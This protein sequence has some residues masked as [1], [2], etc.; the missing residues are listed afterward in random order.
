MRITQN[1][2]ATQVLGNITGSLGRLAKAQEQLASTKR[3]NRASD[4]PLG[5][6][7]VMRFQATK[8]GL[9][10]FQR[11]TDAAQEALRGTATPLERVTEILQ[12][13]REV[14]V[15]GSSDTMSGSRGPLAEEVNQLLE[16]LLSQANSRFRDRYIFGGTQTGTTPYSASRNAT[17][18]ITAVTAN[19]LG[20]D[21]TVNAEVASGFSVQS[22]LPGSQAFTSAVNL[23]DGLVTLRDALTADDTSGIAATMNTLAAGITQVN[24]ASGV[25]GVGVQ[26][27]EA[28]RTRNQEDLT[29]IEALRSQVQ[30]A[31]IAEVYVEL[32]KLQNAFDASLAAGAKAMKAS[33]VDYL[34]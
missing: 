15:R 32:Q 6:G 3:I 34:Q 5:S 1:M 16:E 28:V 17:G 7:L 19:P 30:D 14:A 18:Q 2:V 23:F 10:G 25:I 26:R 24:S 9:E 4:D 29:R 12:Q 27:L 20:I 22:N 11:A 8:E 21:G 13:T 33:L 31:N